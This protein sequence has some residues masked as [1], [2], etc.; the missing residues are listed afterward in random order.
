MYWGEFYFALTLLLIYSVRSNSNCLIAAVGL[1]MWTVLE[2]V[3]YKFGVVESGTISITILFVI[4]NLIALICLKRHLFGVLCLIG[5]ATIS[6]TLI[7]E[8]ALLFKEVK[9]GIY[10]G[11]LSLVWLSYFLDLRHSVS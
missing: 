2:K 3:I 8:N 10:F 5:V 6:W 9:N 11:G 1:L 4:Y 7:A